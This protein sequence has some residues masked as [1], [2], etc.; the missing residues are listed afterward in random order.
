MASGIRKMSKQGTAGK[1]KCLT[2]PQ[3]LEIIMRLESDKI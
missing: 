2:V 3:R 1:M